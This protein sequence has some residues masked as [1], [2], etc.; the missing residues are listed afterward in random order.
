MNC[1]RFIGT[2]EV[3]AGVPVGCT[4]VTG[5]EGTSCG[6]QGKIGAKLAKAVLVELAISGWA[7]IERG[8]PKD[9][10]GSSTT[11]SINI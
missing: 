10:P 9:V 3:A 2:C 6:G 5:S 4:T 1:R 11:I 7:T 8:R